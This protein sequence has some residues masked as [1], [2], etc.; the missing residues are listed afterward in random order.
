M[1]TLLIPAAGLSS[2]YGLARPKFLLQ[3]PSGT[4]MLEAAIS[5]ILK[6]HNNGLSQIVIVTLEEYFHDIDS[7]RWRDRIQQDSGL[8]TS[9]V[10]LPRPTGSMVETIIR[11]IETLD[12]DGPIM[13]R[14]TDSDLA[15]D[16]NADLSQIQNFVAFADLRGYPNVQ[17]GNKSF[18]DLEQGEV[19][20][21]VEK[22]IVSNFAYVGLAKFASASDFVAGAIE[23]ASTGEIYVSDVIRHL[24]DA[25]VSFRGIE[26]SNYE[27]WGTLSDWQRFVSSFQTIFVDIDGVLSRNTHPLSYEKNW[28]SFSA[29]SNNC[30]ALL[31]LER[32]GRTTLV[33]CTARSEESREFLSQ[34][35][36]GFGFES[37]TILLGLPHARRI[38]VNDFAPT[39]PFPSAAAINLPR[40]S[41]SLKD[42]L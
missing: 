35:L 21:I 14:D 6:I 37:P 8:P 2:R 3:H 7:K 24:L 29:L 33:F 42:Y 4:T 23:S 11:G 12:V 32:A 26:V 25:K 28:H 5:G 1:T 20:S 41:D 18:V 19:V 22:N 16:E 13:V 27:D 17:A 38:I 40:D 15:F 30:E 36:E 39:N 10:F 9:I 34:T 31:E